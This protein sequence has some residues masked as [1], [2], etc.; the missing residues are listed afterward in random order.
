MRC[1]SVNNIGIKTTIAIIVPPGG[2]SR[3]RALSLHADMGPGVGGDGRWK[4]VRAILMRRQARVGPLANE[5]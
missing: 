1:S 5:R 4:Q 2:P 3:P